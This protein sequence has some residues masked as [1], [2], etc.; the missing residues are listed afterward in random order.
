MYS[1]RIVYPNKPCSTFDWQHYY[2]V[3][4][5]LG[6]R[7]LREYRGISPLK[8]EVDQHITSD[9]KDGNAPY[10]CICTLYFNSREEVDAM[11]SLFAVEEARRQLAEDWPK[12]TQT[13]PELMVSE[14]VTADPA[15]GRA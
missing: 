1:V 15:T 6:I 8:I 7:L 11:T 9:G 13:D 2:D 14:I 10:H 3:H 5:P 12:Y 4:L